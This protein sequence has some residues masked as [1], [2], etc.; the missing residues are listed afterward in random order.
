MG[1][2]GGVGLFF[3]VLVSFRVEFVSFL[4]FHLFSFIFFLSFHVEIMLGG[5]PFPPVL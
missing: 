4:L 3:L 5:C 2:G 1:G